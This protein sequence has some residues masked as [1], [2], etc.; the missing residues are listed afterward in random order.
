MASTD[1]TYL[2]QGELPHLLADDLLYLS[3]DVVAQQRQRVLQLLARHPSRHRRGVH[4]AARSAVRHRVTLVLVL[5]P[6]VVVVVL[7]NCCLPLGAAGRRRQPRIA[8]RKAACHSAPCCRRFAAVSQLRETLPSTSSVIRNARRI[9]V[10]ERGRE[11]CVV[12]VPA[13]SVIALVFV[14]HRRRHTA[15]IACHR[16]RIIVAISAGCRCSGAAPGWGESGCAAR[17]G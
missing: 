11:R 13:L 7:S 4:G 6:V 14:P 10:I 3:V 5:A 2:G 9:V 1:T 17:Q 8:A 12:A 15:P 16:A